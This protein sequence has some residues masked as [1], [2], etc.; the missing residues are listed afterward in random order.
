MSRRTDWRTRMRAAFAFV[1]H[2]ICQA[3]SLISARLDIRP[4]RSQLADVA[5]WLGRTWRAHLHAA[6]VRRYGPGRGVIAV[7]INRRTN[8]EETPRER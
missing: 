8:T 7:T 1:D 2:L 5:A 4:I 6:H 3:D